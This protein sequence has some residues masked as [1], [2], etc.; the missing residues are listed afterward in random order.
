MLCRVLRCVVACVVRFVSN[1]VLWC[2]VLRD[3]YCGVVVW[4]D[5][6]NVVL[7]GVFAVQ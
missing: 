5:S 7:C 3:A 2:R 1:V 6:L 4:C